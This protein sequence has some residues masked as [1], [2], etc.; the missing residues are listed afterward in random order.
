LF[1]AEADIA[2]MTQ[3]ALARAA[4]LDDL[5][6]TLAATAPNRRSEIAE[7]VT[8]LFLSG[9]EHTDE[10]ADLFAEIL[11]RLIDKIETR[12][13]VTL[14]E[15][16]AGS[17][18]APDSIMQRLA[19]HDEIR[20]A[21]PVL[22]RHLP[23]MDEQLV[24]ISGSRGQAHL[25]AICE[26]P[27]IREPVTD[28]LVRRGDQAVALKVT[29]NP[30]ARFSDDGFET[31]SHRAASDPALS[32]CLGLRADVPRHIFCQILIR[33]NENVRKRMIAAAGNEMHAEIKAVLDQIAGQLA[34]EVPAEHRY[35]QATQALLLRYPG[36]KMTEEDLLGI[37]LAKN[38]NE[39][40]AAVSLVSGLSTAKVAQ[41]L[42]DSQADRVVILAKALGY[43]WSTARAILQLRPKR[44]APDALL[45][46]SEEFS[47]TG[48]RKAQ[49]VLDFW[50]QHELR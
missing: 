15:R 41:A 8:G 22:S 5:E 2:P 28:V 23:L 9:A 31:L 20:V 25:A 7:Q 19:G 49:Q 10:Q 35:E 26:R 48:Q 21:G 33:A 34:D 50:R 4:L 43:S 27:V 40:V 39:L 11:E 6:R 16:L 18:R 14:G 36:G 13:L 42:S 3:P 38:Q 47:R 17:T 30:G 1:T 24:E 12:T 32:E 44:I 29:A 46:A 37:A 45:A